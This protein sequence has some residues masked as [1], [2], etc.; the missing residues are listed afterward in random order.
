MCNVFLII[1]ICMKNL[2]ENRRLQAA[3]SLIYGG[4]VYFRV[5]PVGWGK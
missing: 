1:K 4:G 2:L 5:L 3:S